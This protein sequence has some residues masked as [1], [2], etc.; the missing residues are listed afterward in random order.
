M[1]CAAS[2]KASLEICRRLGERA[3]AVGPADRQARRDRAEDRP[4]G[5]RH[6]RDGG[7]GRAHL[8][9][10]PTRTRSTSGSRPRSR[11]CGTRERA[12]EMANDTLQI[13]GGRGYETARLAEGA[14]RGALPGRAHGPRPAHQPDLRGLERDHAPV[15]RPRGGGRPPLGRGRDGRPARADR[16]SASRPRRQGGAALRVVVSRRASW[17]GACWPR[18]REFGAL[19]RHLRFVD[20]TS[21]RLARS[22]FHAM[23]RF[24]PGL[25]KKQAVLGRIVEIG[26]E[27]F[28]MTSAVREGARAMV[29][30]EPGRPHADR[31]RP[32]CSAA[33]PAAASTRASTSCSTTRTLPPTRSRAECWRAATPGSRKA[34]W[35]CTRA[36]ETHP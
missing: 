6:V 8:A 27:L 26:A 19:A 7:R 21:R 4:H 28:I 29:E 11:R 30:A 23:V 35:A 3:R 1:F 34:W 18:Y 13:R 20:R 32:T 10:W 16:R 5:R 24:G 36:T 33:T 12:W 31:A 22:I 14:R 17:G 25:E 2:G 15:H 9:G